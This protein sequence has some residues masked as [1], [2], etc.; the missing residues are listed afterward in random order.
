MQRNLPL[1]PVKELMAR[2]Q[3]SQ[4]DGYP[5]E[6]IKQLRLDIG[7]NRHAAKWIWI[8]EWKNS[9]PNTP[10]DVRNQGQVKLFNIE[11]NVGPWIKQNRLE[12]H[13]RLC[14]EKQQGDTAGLPV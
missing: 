6:R 2:R 14:N 12:E 11:G 4:D 7:V 5:R 9:L 1:E 13:Q 8:P 10:G 3:I